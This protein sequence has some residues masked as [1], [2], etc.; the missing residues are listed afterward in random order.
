LKKRLYLDHFA[1]YYYYSN[2]L[3]GLCGFRLHYGTVEIPGKGEKKRKSHVSKNETLILF[4]PAGATLVALPVEGAV[5]TLPAT[6]S[7]AHLL[8]CG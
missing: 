4:P 3:L 6:A 8:D 1:L 7:A 2:Y 5:I